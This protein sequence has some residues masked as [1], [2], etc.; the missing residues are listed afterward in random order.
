MYS[1]PTVHVTNTFPLA[2]F[3]PLAAKSRKN[4][5]PSPPKCATLSHVLL[6][7]SAFL[8]LF[9]R[10]LSWQL[11]PLSSQ[12]MYTL[13]RT[14][15][16]LE[17]NEKGSPICIRRLLFAHQVF[18][19]QRLLQDFCCCSQVPIDGEGSAAWM[20]VIEKLSPPRAKC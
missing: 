3:F 13:Q 5:Q 18:F 15:S 12:T 14:W 16:H 4:E 20:D 19:F 2:V 1:V 17:K 8:L 6:S 7:N 11:S 10:S 9:D